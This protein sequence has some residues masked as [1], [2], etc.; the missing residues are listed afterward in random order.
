MPI[1]INFLTFNNNENNSDISKGFETEIVKIK[2]KSPNN[3][4]IE[5]VKEVVGSDWKNEF[6]TFTDKDKLIEYGNTLLVATTIKKELIVAEQ[7]STDNI[8]TLDLTALKTSIENLQ[9]MEIWDELPSENF[10]KEALGWGLFGNSPSNPTPTYLAEIKRLKNKLFYGKL[11]I[12]KTKI[13]EEIATKLGSGTDQATATELTTKLK[14]SKNMHISAWEDYINLG[15]T[16]IG[17]FAL[18]KDCYSAIAEIIAEKSQ[19]DY[20]AEKANNLAKIT[21]L[22]AKCE[23]SEETNELLKVVNLISQLNAFKVW[24]N[25]AKQAEKETYEENKDKIEEK[26][27]ALTEIE[28]SLRESQEEKSRDEKEWSKKIISEA[29]EKIAKDKNI[30]ATGKHQ[31]YETEIANLDE[32]ETVE[33]FRDEII[34]DLLGKITSEEKETILQEIIRPAFITKINSC[35]EP[36]KRLAVL[37]SEL[38]A[39]NQDYESKIN[40]LEKPEEITALKRKVEQNII[41]KRSENLTT[42][43]NAIIAEIKAKLSEKGATAEQVDI[44]DFEQQFI[45]KED[46]DEIAILQQNFLNKINSYKKNQPDIPTDNQ[47]NS[48]GNDSNKDKSP[49]IVGGIAVAF[50]LLIGFLIYRFWKQKQLQKI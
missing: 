23:T 35:L 31:D 29:L 43:I 49:W 4:D 36:E 34:T 37:I 2:H 26:L 30:L 48:T 47:S 27:T 33:N 16:S 20:I 6:S 12:I 44:K 24:E 14:T 17:T 45:G 32:V 41:Q 13:I 8:S 42:H 38:K 11:D 28:T 3:S 10:K 5:T 15:L 19:G 1:T 25:S 21:A 50:G 18:Q 40:T 22:L 7:I 9:E 39:E 46:T